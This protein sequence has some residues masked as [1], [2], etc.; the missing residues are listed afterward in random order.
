MATK[1]LERTTASSEKSKNVLRFLSL[2]AGELIL[3]LVLFLLSRFM[4][5]GLDL[6]WFYT[7]VI[8]WVVC[9]MT[10]LVIA[11]TGLLPDFLRSFVYSL[12]KQEEVTAIQLKR[13]LLSVKLAMIT[14]IT[15]QLFTMAFNYVSLLTSASADNTAVMSA[16]LTVLVGSSVYGILVVLILLPVYARIK[17]R[18]ISPEE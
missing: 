8:L 16:G 17:I 12:K 6:S 10:L 18:L 11:I 7:P 15:T 13:S 4:D 2:F 14:A 5:P 1:I 3:L 9:V